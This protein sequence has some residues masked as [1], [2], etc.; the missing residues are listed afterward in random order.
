MRCAIGAAAAHGANTCWE[1]QLA[2]RFVETHARHQR[3]CGKSRGRAGQVGCDP[4]SRQRSGVTMI[5]AADEQSSSV[6][7][8]SLLQCNQLHLT[9]IE[10]RTA[11]SKYIGL[12][13]AIRRRCL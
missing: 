13:S 6:S 5:I 8:D 2:Q 3:G 1:A 9:L 7:A 4:A 11:A 10:D 12:A